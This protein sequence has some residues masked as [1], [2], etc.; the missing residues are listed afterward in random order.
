MDS[1]VD[2]VL[3]RQI[4][5]AFLG[6]VFDLAGVHIEDAELNQ[7]ICVEFLEASLSMSRM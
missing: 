3:R 2:Q 1:E 7:L 5:I 4:L 6:E